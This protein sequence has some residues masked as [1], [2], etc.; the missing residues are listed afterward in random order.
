MASSL[1]VRAKEALERKRQQGVR[2]A[3]EKTKETALVVGGLASTGAAV[4]AAF[5]DQKMGNGLQWKVGPVPVTAIAGVGALVPAFFAGKMP[6][7][8]AASV[9]IGMTLLNIAL[10]RYLQEEVIAAGTPAP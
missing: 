3:K 7:A 4:G 5:A 9:Q 2:L 8:Q 1:L 10:Y 6:I